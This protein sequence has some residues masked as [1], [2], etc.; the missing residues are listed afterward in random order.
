MFHFLEYVSVLIQESPSV[1]THWR[2]VAGFFTLCVGVSLHSRRVKLLTVRSEGRCIRLQWGVNA[3]KVHL[4][5]FIKS[6]RVYTAFYELT[7]S[8]LSWSCQPVDTE[9]GHL[10]LA[11]LVLQA[12]TCGVLKMML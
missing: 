7:V 12:P 5:S 4:P 6:N 9:E 8:C 10:P 11:A 2:G 1:L 3:H